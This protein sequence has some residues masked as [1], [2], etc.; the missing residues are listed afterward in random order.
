MVFL[1]EKH[2]KNGYQV[3]TLSNTFLEDILIVFLFEIF[4][5]KVFFLKIFLR[6]SFIKYFFKKIP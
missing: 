2:L 4:L 5:L 6:E 1:L 3:E